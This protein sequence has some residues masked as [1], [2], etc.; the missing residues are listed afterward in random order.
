MNVFVNVLVSVG[1][2]FV[3]IYDIKNLKIVMRSY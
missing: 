1:N 2:G 3:G